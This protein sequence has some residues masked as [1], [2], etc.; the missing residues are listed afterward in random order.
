MLLRRRQDTRHCQGLEEYIPDIRLRTARVDVEFSANAEGVVQTLANATITRGTANNELLLAHRHKD[1]CIRS[2][3]A[4][5][6][7]LLSLELHGCQ[8]GLHLSSSKNHRATATSTREPREERVSGAWSLSSSSTSSPRTSVRG[9]R[10][11]WR[12]R[13]QH[14]AP[15]RQAPAK[16]HH[17]TGRLER[18]T[19]STARQP[20]TE[21][22]AAPLVEAAMRCGGGRQLAGNALI[23]EPRSERAVP[24]PP[25]SAV[26]SR[27]G[28]P[29]EL[30][31]WWCWWFK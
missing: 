5:N 29:P 30:W 6:C 31:W 3:R 12:R 10:R 16:A 7:T 20:Q 11:S 27:H 1:A 21:V 4:C 23:M 22:P 14:Q 8:H 13:V 17:H 24:A 26:S 2:P 15:W 25:G 9:G 19:H 28:Q 18:P